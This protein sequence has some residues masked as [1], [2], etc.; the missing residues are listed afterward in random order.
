MP[1]ETKETKTTN[2]NLDT[3]LS[4]NGITYSEGSHV[5]PAEVAADLVRMNKEHNAYLAGLNKNTPSNGNG[6]SRSAA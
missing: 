4:I 6:G 5:V 3:A 2:V 1:T